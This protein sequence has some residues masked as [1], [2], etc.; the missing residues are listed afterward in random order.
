MPE[1]KPTASAGAAGPEQNLHLDHDTVRGASASKPAP[2]GVTGK[3]RAA[4]SDATATVS[5]QAGGVLDAAKDGVRGVYEAASDTVESVRRRGAETHRQTRDWASDRY[6][7]GYAAA[8]RGRG[9]VEDFVTE[10]PVLV[11]VIGLAAGLLLGALLP[12]TRQED[13]TVGAWADEV[14]DQSLRFARDLTS[15]GRDYVE[16]AVDA[17]EREDM[18]A[19]GPAPS[20]RDGVRQGPSGRYQNH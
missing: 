18:P 14:R 9:S 7:S 2:E 12:R 15:R 10:N 17:L 8:R 1:S 5:E 6:E 20:G 13:R 19:G 4:V 11:G 3:V 16:T